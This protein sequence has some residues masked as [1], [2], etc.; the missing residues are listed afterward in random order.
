MAAA[1]ALSFLGIRYVNSR[2]Q[3]NLTQEEARQLAGLSEQG[4]KFAEQLH[5]HQTGPQVEVN[6]AKVEAS[7]KFVMQAAR[8]H[9]IK[10]DAWLGYLFSSVSKPPP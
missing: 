5:T 10:F 6:R 9:G 4:V 7:R 8:E 2:W 1:P 3:L